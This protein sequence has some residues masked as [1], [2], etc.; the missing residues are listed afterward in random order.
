MYKLLSIVNHIVLC[1]SRAVFCNDLR[2]K[3]KQNK[4]KKKK[5]IT[6]IRRS[7][8]LVDPVPVKNLFCPIVSVMI[9]KHQILFVASFVSSAI[10]TK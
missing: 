10:K 7:L 4:R 1:N 6:K 9:A 3:A 5:I 8:L 2:L